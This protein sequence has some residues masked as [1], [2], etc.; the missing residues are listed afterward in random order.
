MDKFKALPPQ[1]KLLIGVGFLGVVAGL[2]Y[3]LVIMSI[4]EQIAQQRAGFAKVQR[5]L[6]EFKDFRG[7]LEIAELREAYAEVVRKIEANKEIIPDDENLPK[8]MA[9]LETAALQSGLTVISKEQKQREYADFF[10]K[11]PIRFAVSGSYLGLVKFLKLIARPRQ[12]LVNVRQ[13]NIES[14]D[15]KGGRR[16]KTKTDD[17]V[18]FSAEGKVAALE[19]RIQ[20][21]LTID[22]FTYI[23]GSKSKD[24]K[25]KKK[26]KGK[27]K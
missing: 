17:D 26:G 15:A 22:G 18:L 21:G 4:D 2:F 5:D 1:Y 12:R 19:S 27:K 23:G 20:A 11:T 7:E 16:K 13:M 25:K 14:L 6:A 3:Y 8:L 10:T 24:K 9:D